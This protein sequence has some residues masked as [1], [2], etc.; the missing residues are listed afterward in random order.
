[1]PVRQTVLT[2][3]MFNKKQVGVGTGTGPSLTLFRSLSLSLSLMFFTK[4]QTST[5]TQ[6]F[7]GLYMNNLAEPLG[8]G[9]IVD[10]RPPPNPRHS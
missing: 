6:K 8:G 3:R 9:R 10:G 2:A 1:M 7:L 5:A 4:S